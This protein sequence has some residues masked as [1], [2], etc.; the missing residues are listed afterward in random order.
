[1]AVVNVAVT[2]RAALMVTLQAEVP[3]H[4]PLQPVNDEPMAGTA[5]SV[6]SVPEPKLA[7]QV[8]PQLMPAGEDVTVPAPLPDFVTDSVGSVDVP[9]IAPYAY[10]EP[11]KPTYTVP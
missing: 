2:D 9:S 4:A 10:P 1:V 3:L 5:D 8:D 6:T 7:L 11:W